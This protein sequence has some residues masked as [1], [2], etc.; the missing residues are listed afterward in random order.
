MEFAELICRSHYSFLHGA[1]APAELIDRA[2]HLGYRAIAITDE[3]SVAGAVQAH[4]AAKALG[5]QLLIGAQFSCADLAGR[6]V[7]IAMSRRGY[8]QLGWL[9]TQTRRRE[10]KATTGLALTIC[11]A[12][13]PTA[14]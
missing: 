2:H 11:K 10:I 4:T 14:F 9:I 5:I 6:I 1:S 8:A 13:C 3:A 7:V 12:G